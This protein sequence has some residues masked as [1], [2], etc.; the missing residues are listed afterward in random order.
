MIEL[1]DQVHLKDWLY[2]LFCSLRGFPWILFWGPFCPC[3]VMRFL[4]C[5]MREMRE[6]REMSEQHN[7]GTNAK[8]VCIPCPQCGK[9]VVLS[10][11]K[12]RKPRLFALN[13]VA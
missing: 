5:C 6:G 3:G 7:D 4:R 2:L 1:F 8:A 9:P 10:G 12:G 13:D 11:P